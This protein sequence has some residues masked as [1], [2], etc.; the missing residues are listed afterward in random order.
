MLHSHICLSFSWPP[1]LLS[2]LLQWTM[3]VQLSTGSDKVTLRV[4]PRVLQLL[5][6]WCL[7]SDKSH[8]TVRSYEV[9]YK[10]GEQRI[11]GIRLFNSHILQKCNS[12]TDRIPIKS[13]FLEVMVAVS[14]QCICIHSLIRLLYTEFF[15]YLILNSCDFIFS[16]LP[17]E[18]SSAVFLFNCFKGC[19]FFLP[20]MNH[21]AYLASFIFYLFS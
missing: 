10:K 11:G 12:T 14:N 5:F 17:T 15:W 18:L 7:S 8:N 21:S 20:P 16:C 3:N 19:L 1:L 4:S 2:D 6:S 13:M 9:H